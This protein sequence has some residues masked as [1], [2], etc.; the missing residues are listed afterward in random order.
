MPPD[1]D[2]YHPMSPPM[3]TSPPITASEVMSVLIMWGT[4][5]GHG[6]GWALSYG[7]GGG[8]Q[9][10]LGVRAGLIM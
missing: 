4:T 9:G 1:S 5:G 3:T 2:A 10:C 7:V 6:E 8:K